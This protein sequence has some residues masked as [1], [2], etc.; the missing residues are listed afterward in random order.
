MKPWN[1]ARGSV[2][3]WGGEPEDY[4]PVHD[5]I[6]ST[7]AAMPDLRHRA[8]LHNAMGIFLCER[9]FGPVIT[10]SDGRHVSVR[11]IAEQHVIEDMGFIPS[12]EDWLDE[13]PQSAWH[14]GIHRLSKDHPERER[15][16]PMALKTMIENLARARK[17]Y[18][19]QLKE[20]GD[21]AAK[22]IAE[23]IAAALPA[24]YCLHWAQY[25]PYFNDGEPCEFSVHDAYLR[26]IDL[27]EDAEEREDAILEILH[28]GR[29]TDDDIYLTDSY[30]GSE[31]WSTPVQEGLS[32]AQMKAVKAIWDSLP[33]DMLEAAFGDHTAVVVLGDG[34]H[35]TSEY[36]HD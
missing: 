8:V 30:G 6:D 17:Q 5:F 31:R 3:K 23:A 33:E 24:G 18:E 29:E 1:H 21:G 36:E 28:G 22:G 16:N 13:L 20:L 19:D 27:P 25:T 10:N 35:H 34:T 4:L 32:V 11:D 26:K 2:K 12:L 15:R 9:V 14:G 7:K